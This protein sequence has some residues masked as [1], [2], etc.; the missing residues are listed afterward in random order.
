MAKSNKKIVD[1]N[2]SSSR[3]AEDFIVK[4]Q[5]T[6]SNIALGILVVI[7]AFYAYY[8]YILLPQEEEAAESMYFSELYYRQDSLQLAENGDGVNYSFSYIKDHFSGTKAA[9]LSNYYLGQIYFDQGKLDEALDVLGDFSSE[10]PLLAAAAYG[11]M[12]DVY[13]NKNE[14]QN[15]L[16]FYQKASSHDNQ[17]LAPYFLLKAAKVAIYLEEYSK[18]TSLLSRIKEA[19]PEADQAN[20]VEKYITYCTQM[21]GK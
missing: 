17:I 14:L 7:A 9:S 1:I 3:N 12:G 18:A 20:E 21:Q 6:I 5:K 13:A 11:T 10:D 15:A 2:K 16:S 4:N 19:Y 8:N